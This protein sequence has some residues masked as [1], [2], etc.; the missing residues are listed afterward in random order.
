M[1]MKMAATRLKNQAAD[2]GIFQKIM[3][4]DSDSL[5]SVSPEFKEF[6]PKLP[7]LMKSPNH[8]WAAK[9]YMLKAA[10]TGEFGDFD[11]VIYADAGCEI[12]NNFASRAR[13]KRSLIKAGLCDVGVAQQ[14]PYLEKNYTKKRTLEYLDPTRALANTLQIQATVILLNNCAGSKEFVNDWIR[15]SNPSLNLW[16][17]PSFPE[18]E[19]IGHRHDQSIFSILWKKRKLPTQ[20]F[21]WDGARNKNKLFDFLTSSYAI[22]A[23]RNRTGVSSISSLYSTNIFMVFFAFILLRCHELVVAILNRVK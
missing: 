18:P 15:F 12:I 17:D 4:F 19:L 11:Q 8:F 7:T 22:Q 20:K 21:Y 16:Q 10:L 2:L 13:L 1:D 5:A 23:I 6:R 14:I 3:Q 9:P